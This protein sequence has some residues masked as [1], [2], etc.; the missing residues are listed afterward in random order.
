[1]SAERVRADA[2]RERAAAERGRANAEATAE[3]LLVSMH[4]TQ[5][6]IAS[7]RHAGAQSVVNMG[8]SLTSYLAGLQQVQV[9]KLPLV[10]LV[11]ASVPKLPI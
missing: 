7:H 11:I 4:H 2:E 5:Q 10:P 1:M 6:S 8:E 9:P 3:R